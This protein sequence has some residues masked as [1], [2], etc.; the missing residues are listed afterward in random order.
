MLSPSGRKASVA[1]TQRV[2]ARVQ[3]HK[4]WV[5]G[6]LRSE[7]LWVSQEAAVVSWYLHLDKLTPTVVQRLD[8]GNPQREKL[9]IH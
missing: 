1:G 3:G 5:R 7:L 2:K 8:C 9:E 6:L 4:G